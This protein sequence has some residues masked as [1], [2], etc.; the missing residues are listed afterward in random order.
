MKIVVTGGA[1]FIGGNLSIY[2]KDRGYD[3]IAIDSLERASNKDL[4][5]DYGVKLMVLDL[6]SSTDIPRADTIIHAAAYIDVDESFRKPYD[7]IV[8]NTAVTMAIARKALDYNAKLIYLSS[9]AVYGEP[10]YVPIDEDHPK[11]PISPYGLSKL[12]GEHAVLFYGRLGLRYAIVRPFN[13]YGL[14]QSGSYTGVISKFVERVRRGEPPVIYGD[15]SQ[16]RDF[17]HVSDLSKLIERIIELDAEG[18][19]NAGSGV[20]TRI[21]DL[22]RLILKLANLELEP[23]YMDA[24]L[25]DIKRSCADIRR[26][27]SLGWSVEKTLEEGLRELLYR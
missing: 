13:V 6:R 16:T 8:N 2:L 23:V 12:M 3:V 22:A 18:V 20:E 11:E 9:A 7:Y 1:G 15:G 4:L 5:E 14:G 10:R 27:R 17:I 21:V 26:A 25:G 24:R 19:Y